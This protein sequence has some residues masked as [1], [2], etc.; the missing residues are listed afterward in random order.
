VTPT[1]LPNAKPIL[2]EN[3]RRPGY[4]QP[5]YLLSFDHRHSFATGM[6]HL[7]APLTADQREAVTDSKEVIYDGFRQAL[8]PAVPLAAAG[9]L[10]DEEFGAAVLRDAA[11]NGYVTALSTEKSD[12]AEFEFEY[13]AEFGSH[14]AALRPTFAKALV[15]YN[16]EGDA[17]VNQRQIAR[18]KLLSDYCRSVRQRFMV[19]LLVPATAAQQ[20]RVEAFEKS[21]DLFLRPALTVQT[22]CTLQ[23]AGIEPD[24]WA[25][26]GL[27]RR[28]DCEH[29]LLTVRR[30]GRS[31]VGC[32]VLGHDAGAEQ[33]VRWLET[34]ASVPGF[35][36]FAVGRT[37]FRYAVAAYV[38]K[39]VTYQEAVSLV[40]RRYREWVGVFERARTRLRT[41]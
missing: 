40:A 33:V 28:S 3:D 15:R 9:I 29:V 21:Y 34:A 6:F 24:V 4:D 20:D 12:S 41:A 13:G 32:I 23:D 35:I 30:N 36:G 17:A 22:I 25:I 16:P 38:A 18:L 5:L 11:R 39:H 27:D 37:T 7:G 14:I 10:I 26:Q 1:T 2:G 19:E 31:R 8:G